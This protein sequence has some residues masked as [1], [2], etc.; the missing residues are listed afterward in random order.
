MGQKQRFF[1]KKREKRR[2]L[3]SIP[4]E[5]APSRHIVFRLMLLGSPPDM[6][7][8]HPLRETE[9]LNANACGGFFFFKFELVYHRLW[10]I[11]SASLRSGGVSAA[12]RGGDGG[13]GGFAPGRVTFPAREK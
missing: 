1:A 6:V 8:G 13:D 2:T 7:H 9:L 3:P 4:S 5:S 11:T 10:E 12:F